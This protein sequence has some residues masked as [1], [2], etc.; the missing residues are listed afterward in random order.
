MVFEHFKNSDDNHLQISVLL[1]LF[2]RESLT[3]E[4]TGDLDMSRENRILFEEFG[5]M[6]KPSLK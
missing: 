5:R 2:G 1:E 3:R 6:M 4:I